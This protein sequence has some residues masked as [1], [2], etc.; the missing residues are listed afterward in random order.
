M[1]GARAET[2]TKPRPDRGFVVF[3]W[4]VY[5]LLAADVVLYA[6]F[7]RATELLDT[8]AWFVLL[9]L[10]EWE[11]GGWKLPTRWRPALHAVRA[12]AAVAVVTA[13]VGYALE[14]V[15]LDFANE[16]VWLG[17]IALLELEVRLPADA[18]VLHRIRRATAA[19]LYLALIGFMLTWVAMGI[20]AGEDRHAAWLDAWDAF[21]WLVAFVAI[22]LNVFELA[23]SRRRDLRDSH[24][25]PRS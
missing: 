21:L 16:M 11:T 22:E 1:A 17:V 25:A 18:V 23:P 9:L 19:V 7:G 5:A 2:R 12:L 4:L 6:R 8:A 20:A 24:P 3:R 13:C 10:F 15:W 14:R